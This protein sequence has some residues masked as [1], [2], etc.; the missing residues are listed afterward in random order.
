MLDAVQ[1]W[2]YVLRELRVLL[3]PEGSTT[4]GSS[5]RIKCAVLTASYAARMNTSA[6]SAWEFACCLFHQEGLLKVSIKF[7]GAQ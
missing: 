5:C 6:T 4:E 3:S 1:P 7:S 2:H